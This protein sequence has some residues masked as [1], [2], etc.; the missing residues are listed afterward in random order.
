V[1]EREAVHSRRQ[2]VDQL[3]HQ[4]KDRAAGSTAVGRSGLGA[5]RR[6]YSD[7]GTPTLTVMVTRRHVNPCADKFIRLMS[8]LGPGAQWKR[9]SS[10][11]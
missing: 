10:E 7:K 3:A 8:A 5:K 2:E 6:T 4:A 1:A 11:G 9:V